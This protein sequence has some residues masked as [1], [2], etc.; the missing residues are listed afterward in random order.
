VM[1]IH[2]LGS[3]VRDRPWR[4]ILLGN[5]VVIAGPP[6]RFF[7]GDDVQNINMWA[8]QRAQGEDN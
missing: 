4:R 5:V 6:R 3:V 7:E 1:D 8:L 2:H